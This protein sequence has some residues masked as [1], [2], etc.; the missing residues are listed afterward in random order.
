MVPGIIAAVVQRK[1]GLYLEWTARQNL[2]EFARRGAL[3]GCPTFLADGGYDVVLVLVSCTDIEG[4]LTNA[5]TRERQVP[6]DLI[7]QFNQD[8]SKHF[9]EAAN[10]LAQHPSCNL[11]VFVV[12]GPPSPRAHPF[13]VF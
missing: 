2:Q 13:L 6:P 3:A 8:R 11:R 5:A 12:S 10:A 4:I 9:V 7:R 1:V